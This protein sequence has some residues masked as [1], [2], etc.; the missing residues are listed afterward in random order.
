MKKAFTLIELLVVV[1]IMGILS[2]VALPQYK[3]A[4]QKAELA[5]YRLIAN[6]VAQGAI[7]YHLAN[8]KWPS[9]ID[10][11]DVS[12]PHLEQTSRGNSCVYNEKMFCCLTHPVPSGANGSVVCGKQDNSFAYISQF[13]DDLGESK[14]MHHC[15]SKPELKICLASGGTI[16]NYNA[17]M[18]TYNGVA[19]S[20]YQYVYRGAE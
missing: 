15:M 19:S 18:N 10:E 17:K 3:I 5:N 13:A 9:N 6:T 11:L 4:I 7:A 12:L 8:G 20:L 1:L 16:N 14:N 2:A